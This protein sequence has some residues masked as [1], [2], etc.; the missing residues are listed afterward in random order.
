MSAMDRLGKRELKE[1]LCKGWMT[2]DAMWLLHCVEV[3]GMEKTNKINTKAVYSMSRIEINRVKKALGYSNDTIT[4]FDDLKELIVQTM[5][6]IKADFMDFSWSTPEKNVLHWKWSKGSCFAYQGIKGLGVLD[7]Y[8]C[9]VMKRIEGWM[10]G[11]GVDYKLVPQINGCLMAGQDET[12]EG[13][14]ILSLE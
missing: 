1:L 10:Q 13:D 14:F 11:L 5:E 12:C 6:L 4:K 3:L 7:E 9:G 2:H 8:E